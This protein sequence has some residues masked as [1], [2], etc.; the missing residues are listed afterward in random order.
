MTRALRRHL[1]DDALFSLE[2]ALLSSSKRASRGCFAKLNQLLVVDLA[3][4]NRHLA[5]RMELLDLGWMAG[6]Q[7]L[8]DALAVGPELRELN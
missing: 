2:M 3:I 4:W 5:G 8:P 1:N 6:I 7:V